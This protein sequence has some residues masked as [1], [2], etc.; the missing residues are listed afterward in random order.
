MQSSYL[1]Y[2]GKKQEA[3]AK[4]KTQ[5]EYLIKLFT[6]LYKRQDQ[7]KFLVLFYRKEQNTTK[8]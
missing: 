7:P 4:K 8:A 2:N 6:T 1:S 3:F 5:S